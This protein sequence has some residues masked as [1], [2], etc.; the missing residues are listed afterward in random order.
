[1]NLRYWLIALSFAFL[2]P[3]TGSAWESLDF[4]EA[5]QEAG[6]QNKDVLVV[7]TAESMGS[8][9][10]RW[11]DHL[12]NNPGVA[13]DLGEC[14]VLCHTVLPSKTPGASIEAIRA[15]RMAST[16]GVGL[17]PTMILCD[18]EGKAYGRILGGVKSDGEIAGLTE[19]LKKAVAWKAN[20]DQALKSS[21]NSSGK[22]KEGLMLKGLAMVPASAWS[23]DYPEIMRQL[24]VLGSQAVAYRNALEL[25][26]RRK[27]EERLSSLMLR[28]SLCSKLTEVNRFLEEL[29]DV[30]K[31]SSMRGETRQFILLNG[32]Y[33][34]LVKKARL[35]HDGGGETMEAEEAFDLSVKTLEQVRNMDSTSYWGREAHRIR[36]DLRRARLSAA[37]FD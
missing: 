23:S 5:V 13:R 22:E 6:R 26:K 34:L 1:M 21:R 20:R 10:K 28:A 35:L 11:R 32:R 19:Q 4:R 16:H 7:Y 36:E 2:F 18:G 27:Q 29:D 8:A 37:R 15:V 9:G 24:D 31:D 17:L 33:P 12:L 3:S 14:F 30:L 25:E